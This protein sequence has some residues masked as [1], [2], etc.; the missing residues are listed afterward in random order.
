MR[1]ILGVERL[2]KYD[3]LIRGKRIGLITN[4]SGILPDWSQDT[5]HLLVEAGYEIGRAHV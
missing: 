4:F 5:A 3:S 1:L 2:S